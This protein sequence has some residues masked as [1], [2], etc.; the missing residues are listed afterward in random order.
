[1]TDDLYLFRHVPDRRPCSS[2]GG[3]WEIEHDVRAG[4]GAPEMVGFRYR[5]KG[6][7]GA[8]VP[9]LPPEWSTAGLRR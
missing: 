9:G 2:A 8:W 5:R 4:L 1:M 6:E 3:Q 7:A